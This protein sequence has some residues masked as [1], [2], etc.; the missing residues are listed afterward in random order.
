VTTHTSRHERLM[1]RSGSRTIDI[2]LFED[3]PVSP[4]SRLVLTASKFSSASASEAN[5]RLSDFSCVE[6][7]SAFDS[8]SRRRPAP[9]MFT[10]HRNRNKA[11]TSH[12][13]HSLRTRRGP[14]LFAVQLPRRVGT[15]GA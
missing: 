7:R 11:L 10:Q 6:C 9:T 13:V 12:H 1:S 4:G 15:Y 2:L 5:N 8:A 3:N 14:Q